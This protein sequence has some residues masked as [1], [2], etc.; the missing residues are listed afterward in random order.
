[1]LPSQSS[2]LHFRLRQATKQLHHVLDHHPL[3]APLVSHDLTRVQY[4]DALEA[5]HGVQ[6]QAEEGIFEFLALHPGLFDYGVRRKVPALEAD[7]AALGRVPVRLTMNPPALTSISDLVGVLY[8][9]EGSTQGGQVIARLLRQL[10]IGNLPTSFFDGYGALS[11]QRW[12]EFLQFA[13]TVCPEQE[14]EL[15]AGAAATTFEAIGAHLD[16]YRDH[17]VA[18]P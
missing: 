6:V 8:T 11:H 12:K 5:L 7:L 14:W 15:A 9:L 2:G 17:L 13:D 4:G 10:P 16:A 18:R 1:M 3:L